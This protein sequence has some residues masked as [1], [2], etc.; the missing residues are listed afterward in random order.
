MILGVAGR[1]S[2]LPATPKIMLNV[3]LDDYGLIEERH[4]GCPL[5]SFGYTTHLRQIRSYSK[6]TGAGVT[7]IGT[8]MVRT[9]S[10]VSGL[11]SWIRAGRISSAT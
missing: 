1:T 8:E 10:L 7:L 4:C 3:Q 2:L 5:E 9:S 11:I 6:L